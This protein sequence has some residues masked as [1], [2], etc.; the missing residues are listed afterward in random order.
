MVGSHPLQQ[1]V[2]PR[3]LNPRHRTSQLRRA[4]VVAGELRQPDA[5]PHGVGAVVYVESEIEKIVAVGDQH[6]A[7]TSRDDLVELQTEGPGVAKRAQTAPAVSRAGCLADVLD[8]DEVVLLRDRNELFHRGR[9]SA[10]VHRENRACP[11]RDPPL[12]VGRIERQ[13]LVHLGEDGK[14]ARGKHGVRRRVPRVRRDDH[15]VPFTDARADQGA[16]QC[17]GTRVEAERVL[18]AHVRCELA[19]EGEDLVRP[20]AD[21]VVAEEILALDHAAEGFELLL[22]HLHPAGKHRSLRPGPG[23]GSPV[24]GEGQVTLGPRGRRHTGRPFWT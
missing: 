21:A 8:Q 16:D 11:R 5:A 15:L 23:R 12:D 22:P 2:E 18:R 4:E 17:G 7:L 20:L 24:P 6:A 10:H 13:R 19:L 14:G 1:A 3:Q 9:R